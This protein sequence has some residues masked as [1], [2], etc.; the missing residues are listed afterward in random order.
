MSLSELTSI[1]ARANIK[2]LWLNLIKFYEFRSRTQSLDARRQPDP[3]SYNEELQSYQIKNT[4]FLHWLDKS[5]SKP[6]WLGTSLDSILRTNK[7]LSET[8]CL[9]L[10]FLFSSHLFYVRRRGKEHSFFILHGRARE[11]HRLLLVPLLPPAYNREVRKQLD[12]I[13]IEPGVMLGANF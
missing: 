1:K 11:Q 6:K 5:E 13:E 12:V 3:C 8:V 9:R 10:S 4:D 2:L 7:A